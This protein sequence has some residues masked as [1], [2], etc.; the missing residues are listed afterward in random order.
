MKSVKRLIDYFSKGELL[1]FGARSVILIV[2]IVLRLRSGRSSSTTGG[3]PC[4]ASP[5]LIYPICE[6]ESVRAISDGDI[7]PAV[8]KLFRSPSLYYGEML[9][10]FSERRCP[11]WRY[12]RLYSWLRNPHNGNKA[13]VKVGSLGKKEIVFMWVVAAISNR[14]IL[15]RYRTTFNTANI[16]PSAISGHDELCL[17]LPDFCRRGQFF[18]LGY[19]ANDVV[20]IVLWVLASIAD[21]RYC[22]GRRTRFAA[23]LVNDIYGF[24]SWRKMKE[25]QKADSAKA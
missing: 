11:P 12:L 20:L 7:Q 22:F 1:L 19:A 9:S 10:L 15:F 24:L 2:G 5:S 6:G 23:F 13:E 21:A 4:S 17:R 8:L 16:V 25:R 18:A 3:V 14:R